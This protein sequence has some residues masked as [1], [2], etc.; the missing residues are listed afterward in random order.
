MSKYGRYAMESWG[1]SFHVRRL[2]NGQF[3]VKTEN[4]RYKGKEWTGATEQEAIS[5]AKAEINTDMQSE[6]VTR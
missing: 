5:K 3:A 2:D 6:N 4:L 1:N